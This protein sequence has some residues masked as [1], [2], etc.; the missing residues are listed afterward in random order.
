[1][2][3]L[4]L[5]KTYKKINLIFKSFMIIIIQVGVIIFIYLEAYLRLLAKIEEKYIENHHYNHNH[6]NINHLNN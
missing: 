3:N 2:K 1:M 6:N 4:W 5:I